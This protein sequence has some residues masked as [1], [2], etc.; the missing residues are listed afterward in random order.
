MWRR[1]T[2][3]KEAQWTL[4]GTEDRK[5]IQYYT[6][7]SAKKKTFISP[8]VLQTEKVRLEKDLLAGPSATMRI[9][10]AGQDY[11]EWNTDVEGVYT[12]DDW[13]LSD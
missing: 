12:V 11:F 5:D 10:A 2:G 13:T 4:F 6:D 7:M 1:A 9:I 8:R 3:L